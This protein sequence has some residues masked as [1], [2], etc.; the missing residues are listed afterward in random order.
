LK[1]DYKMDVYSFCELCTDGGALIAVYDLTTE[2]EVFCG[3]MDDARWEDFSE[4][5]VLSFDICPPDGR[6][7]T[8]ILNIETEEGDEEW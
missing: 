5:D 4:C 6:G 8:L 1:G 7:V 3:T 2:E